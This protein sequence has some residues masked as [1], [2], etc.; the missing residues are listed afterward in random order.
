MKYLFQFREQKKRWNENREMTLSGCKCGQYVARTFLSIETL[1]DANTAYRLFKIQKPNQ[2]V[3]RKWTIR[4]DTVECL[5]VKY[6]TIDKEDYRVEKFYSKIVFRI[7]NR[8][9]A[10]RQPRTTF[11]SSHPFFL[12][13]NC[14]SSPFSIHQLQS[15]VP[16]ISFSPPHSIDES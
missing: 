8:C 7:V 6:T 15:L 1:D 11:Y 4:M 14:L 16:F 3:F 2:V 12:T 10:T 5:P 13:N 9:I